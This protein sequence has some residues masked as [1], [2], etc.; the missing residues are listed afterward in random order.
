MQTKKT[1]VI[2]EKAKSNVLGFGPTGHGM[3]E[4]MKSCAT[5]GAFLG[6]LTM[7][8]E[9]RKQCCPP[10]KKAAEPERKKK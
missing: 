7:M 5:Q 10:H 1:R 4:M 2:R 3:C 6:C 8:E 9:M